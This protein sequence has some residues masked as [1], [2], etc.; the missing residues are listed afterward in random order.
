MRTIDLIA[1]DQLSRRDC[2]IRDYTL[3]PSSARRKIDCCWQSDSVKLLKPRKMMGSEVDQLP[4]TEAS[5]I[6]PT[7]CDYHAVFALDGF[8]CNGFGQVDGEKDRVHLAPNGI[9]R[10]FQQHCFKSVGG[11]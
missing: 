4:T 7:V 5:E 3:I 10:S 11:Y 2:A 9:E 6:W 1:S 8:I